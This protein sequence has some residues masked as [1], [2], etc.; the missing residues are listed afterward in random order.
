MSES[1]TTSAKKLES[2]KRGL[3]K[4]EIWTNF[5]QSSHDV[6]ITLLRRRFNVLTSFP[7]PC[8]VVLTSFVGRA[9]T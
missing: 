9:G 3:E 7:R 1:E 4:V 8:N 6:G 5:S 2:D